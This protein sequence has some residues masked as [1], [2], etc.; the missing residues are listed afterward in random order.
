MSLKNVLSAYLPYMLRRQSC[1]RY[2]VVNREYKPVGFNTLT[3]TKYEPF[4]V[5]VRI[6]GLT[7]LR[8]SKISFNG[9]SSLIDIRLYDDGC[10]PNSAKRKM[11]DYLA[12]LAVLAKLSSLATDSEEEKAIQREATEKQEIKEWVIQNAKERKE[13]RRQ[14]KLEREKNSKARALVKE[15]KVGVNPTSGAFDNLET[16]DVF[17]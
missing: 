3:F 6:K 10:Y 1:G 11:D 13:W 12:R 9:S 2:V 16:F 4:P 8:A 17:R 7:P 14:L 5:L 15:L